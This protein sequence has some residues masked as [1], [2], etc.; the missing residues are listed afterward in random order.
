MIADLVQ[1]SIEFVMH[2][3]IAYK[4]ALTLI[5]QGKTD[6]EIATLTS[7]LPEAI[8]FLRTSK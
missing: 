7:L 6:S 3:Q 8:A 5:E 4:T 1:V 2:L